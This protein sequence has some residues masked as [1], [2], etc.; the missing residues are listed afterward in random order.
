MLTQDEMAAKRKRGGKRGGENGGTRSKTK[1]RSYYGDDAT[2]P[3][4]DTPWQ[5]REI[6]V[7]LYQEPT[8]QWRERLPEDPPDRPGFPATDR[9]VSLWV[10][11]REAQAENNRLRKKL[12]MEGKQ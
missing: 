9:M 4:S 3:W 5:A 10:K 1:G 7:E 2:V 6:E 11:L 12:E 8:G